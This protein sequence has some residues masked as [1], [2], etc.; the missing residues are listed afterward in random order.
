MVF[1]LGDED[2]PD[3]GADKTHA[4]GCALR[5]L[6]SEIT[7]ELLYMHLAMHTFRHSAQL[8]W[9]ATGLKNIK[10]QDKFTVVG[11][12]KFL[13][14]CFGDLPITVGMASMPVHSYFLPYNPFIRYPPG[15]FTHQYVPEKPAGKKADSQHQDLLAGRKV[16]WD[17]AMTFGERLPG[18][19]W[20]VCDDFG[21]D[22]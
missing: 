13:D 18:R 15:W 1:Y 12:E 11:D 2:L 16:L 17:A 4:F 7:V 20:P 21:P 10:V 6:H 3:F 19:L 14:M 9:F 22:Y 5:Y 8:S